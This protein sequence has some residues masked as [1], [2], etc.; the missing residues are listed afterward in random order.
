MVA[1]LQATFSNLNVFLGAHFFL[2]SSFP[3]F[4]MWQV[5]IGSDNS[6]V[7]KRWQIHLL[8]PKLRWP[9]CR[10]TFCAI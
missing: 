7:T 2:Y 1:I 9:I 5:S 10:R 4:D 3:S 6:L 8:N